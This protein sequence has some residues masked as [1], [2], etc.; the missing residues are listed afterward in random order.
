MEY[1]ERKTDSILLTSYI[2]IHNL[3]GLLDCNFSTFLPLN[4]VKESD[5]IIPVDT[6]MTEFSIVANDITF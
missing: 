4:H 1:L 2:D 3:F 6:D 5:I